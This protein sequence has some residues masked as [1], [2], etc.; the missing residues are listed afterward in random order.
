KLEGFL[1]QVA[2]RQAYRSWGR[3]CRVVREANQR[4]MKSDRRSWCLHAICNARNDLQ[5]W[6]HSTFYEEVYR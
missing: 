6:Y 3:W 2:T 1:T 4:R 5:A